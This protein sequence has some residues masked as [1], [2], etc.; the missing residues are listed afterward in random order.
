[1]VRLPV[2]PEILQIE[3]R[4]MPGFD[5]TIVRLSNVNNVPYFFLKDSSK[6][7]Q[8]TDGNHL[9]KNSSKAVTMAIANFI[10]KNRKH[11]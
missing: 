2:H 5:D 4:L 7:Y 6:K 9:Y 3:D 10:M 1:M 11:Q 8:Y